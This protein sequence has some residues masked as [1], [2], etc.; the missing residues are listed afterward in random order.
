MSPEKTFGCSLLMELFMAMPTLTTNT[1]EFINGMRKAGKLAALT[2]LHL[3]NLTKPG[4]TT[5]QLDKAAFDFI[6][7]NGATPAPLGYK[8][9]PKSI[10]TSVNSVVCHR[11]NIPQVFI[12][13]KHFL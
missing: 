3:R 2:L 4:I 11:Y 8:G 9:F 13:N 5:N 12:R 6:T 10:C 1:N 7:S